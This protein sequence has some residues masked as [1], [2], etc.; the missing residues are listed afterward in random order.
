LI[1]EDEHEE[2]AQREQIPKSPLAHHSSSTLS[3]EVHRAIRSHKGVCNSV[4]QNV[5][6][7]GKGL[8]AYFEEYFVPAEYAKGQPA[9][10]A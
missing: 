7:M 6:G 3:H 9:Y 2:Y 5:L 10:S 8:D 4:R 1:I